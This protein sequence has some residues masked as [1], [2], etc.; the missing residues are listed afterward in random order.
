MRLHVAR[1]T[2][3]VA[4]HI[5]LEEAGAEYTL[6]WIDFTRGDQTHPDYLAVNPKGRV[7][8]LETPHGVLTEAAAILTYIADTH[9]AASLMPADPFQRARVH[10][11][12][13]T[14]AATV[15]VNHAHKLRG[16]RW[17]NDPAAH[18][19]MAAKVP[20]NMT[21]NAAL[22]QDHFLTGPWVLGDAFSTADIY[23][24][25]VARWFAGD[26]VDMSAFPA[27]TVHHTA[28]MQR[29]AVQNVMRHHIS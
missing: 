23:L 19:A 21:A 24:F 25:T 26:G 17:A 15:H 27:L 20:Q 11:L 8:A 9:P 22:L 13:L 2:V 6:N 16:S 1:G 12:H 5:A 18:T 28:M 14:L 7:P 3:A 10:E 29:S 4:P